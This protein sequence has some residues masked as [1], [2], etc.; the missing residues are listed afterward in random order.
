MTTR[1]SKFDKFIHDFASKNLKRRMKFIF[2]ITLCLMV[3]TVV[4]GTYLLQQSFVIMET[5]S[6]P[7]QESN[8]VTIELAEKYENLIQPTI[9]LYGEIPGKGFV[10]FNYEII[11]IRFHE[12]Q[13]KFLVQISLIDHLAELK[14][15]TGFTYKLYLEKRSYL[16]LLLESPS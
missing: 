15:M 8:M 1:R 10:E 5:G 2:L 6:V 4:S 12:K 11:E 13:R 7:L 14:A 16:S 9:K 3:M